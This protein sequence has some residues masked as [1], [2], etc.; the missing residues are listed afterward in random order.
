MLPNW[1]IA[2]VPKAATSTLFRWLVDHPDVAGPKDK[3][4]YY[5]V[6]RG[7]HM[8]RPD[9][10]FGDHGLAGYERL[11][12]HADPS[13]K[14]VVEATPGYIYYETALRTLPSLPTHPSFIFLLREPV[15]QLRSLHAY[16][17][18]NWDWIPRN[19][20][21]RQFI[22]AVENGID[23]FNGNELAA[24]A[25]ANASYPAHLRKWR[26]AVGNDRMLVLLFEDL[27][28]DQRG[29]MERVARRLGLDPAF[30]LS[31]GF[32]RENSTYAVRSGW[33]QD[34]NIRLRGRL[35]QGRLYDQ[36]RALYRAVNTRPAA[37]NRDAELESELAERFAAVMPE[38]EREFGLDM[39]SWR[40]ELD[41]FRSAACSTLDDAG[42]QAPERLAV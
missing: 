22:K 35:P 31:Y 3:E 6:D 12:D 39:S 28:R 13:A 25:L 15:A 36:A 11:F 5:F 33:L 9:R 37:L 10:N 1:I 16:F 40:S 20:S 30:Y 17:R 23:G 21:F 24:N 2:G 14:V 38:L 4:T 7:T 27:V 8:F 32:P 41:N 29:F 34:L 26:N 18:Q 19:M 42:A